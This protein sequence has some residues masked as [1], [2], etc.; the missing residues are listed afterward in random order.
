LDHSAAPYD[1]ATGNLCRICDGGH[2]FGVYFLYQ[3]GKVCHLIPRW[4]L[5]RSASSHRGILIVS[6]TILM[7]ISAHIRNFVRFATLILLAF[8]GIWILKKF[9]LATIPRGFG[10]GLIIFI[11]SCLLVGIFGMIWSLARW[12]FPRKTTKPIIRY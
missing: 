10:L 8:Y 7:K 3:A 5:W 9:E 4:G 1:D 12:L 6:P 11:A 2:L